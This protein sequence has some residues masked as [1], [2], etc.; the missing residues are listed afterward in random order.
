MIIVLANSKTTIVLS[1]TKVNVCRTFPE[2]NNTS[3]IL[4]LSRK[5]PQQPDLYNKT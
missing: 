1:S 2:N 4:I 3:F 5:V